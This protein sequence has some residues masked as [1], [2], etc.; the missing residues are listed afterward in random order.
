MEPCKACGHVEAQQCECYNPRPC[1]CC[2]KC[3][4][5]GNPIVS[6]Y[7]SNLQYTN[8]LRWDSNSLSRLGTGGGN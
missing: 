8:T 3:R 1:S 6:P 5:C 2:G 4:K 7:T